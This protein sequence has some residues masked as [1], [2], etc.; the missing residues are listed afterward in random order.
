LATVNEKEYDMPQQGEFQGRLA[1]TRLRQRGGLFVY[2]KTI[3]EKHIKFFVPVSTPSDMRFFRRVP[4]GT[5]LHVE[6]DKYLQRYK[7]I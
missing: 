5:N 3:T 1:A 2:L 4:L 7:R 6:I